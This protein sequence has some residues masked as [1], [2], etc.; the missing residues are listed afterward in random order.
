MGRNEGKYLGKVIKRRILREKWKDEES[1]KL[2]KRMKEENSLGKWSERE[3]KL[4]EKWKDE[5]KMKLWKEMNEKIFR[6][7]EVKGKENSGK[8]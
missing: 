8:N 2:R 3:G 1:V 5:E 7:G 6:K 4:R